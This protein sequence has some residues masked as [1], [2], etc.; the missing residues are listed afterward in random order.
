MFRIPLYIGDGG[1]GSV[2]QKTKGVDFSS[3]K[4]KV[5]T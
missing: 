4:G 5:I 2:F 1:R 3:Q